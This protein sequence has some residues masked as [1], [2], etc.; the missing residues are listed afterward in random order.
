MSLLSFLSLPLVLILAPDALVVAE[1]LTIW[2]G[3]RSIEQDLHCP[4]LGQVLICQ[5]LEL[6]EDRRERSIEVPEVVIGG[7]MLRLQGG[8]G[9]GDF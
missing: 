7:Q 2:T 4:E 6:G 9:T 3:Q 1:F 5:L 8:H